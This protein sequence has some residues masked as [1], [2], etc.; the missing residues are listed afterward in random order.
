MERKGLTNAVICGLTVAATTVSVLAVTAAQAQEAA[1]KP[2]SDETKAANARLLSE[3]PFNNT[4]EFEDA[5]AGFVAPLPDNG[6]VKNDK[7]QPVYDLSK[8][9]AFIAE[10]KSAPDTV[11]PSLWRQSQL[12]MLG[13]LFKVADS[14]YQVRAADLSNITFIEAPDG[15]II[16]DPLIS[17]ETAKYALDLYYAHRP[18]KPVVAVIYSH[19]HVDHYGGVR[20]VAS[21]DDVKS[22][23]VK[24]YAPQGFLDA[25][26]AENVMAGNAMSRRASYMYGNLLPRVPRARWGPVLDQRLHLA[27]SPLSRRRTSSKRTARRERLPDWILNSGW[28]RVRKLRRRCSSTFL[29]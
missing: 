5:K 26:V 13:G 8:F 21:E 15:V 25:A 10:S 11:N 2:A 16:V 18:K 14:I 6:V 7:G 24:I 3:L 9:T 22:G 27:P 12:L 20:G 4:Q 1:A 23:K 28:P 19:S 17:E 29:R